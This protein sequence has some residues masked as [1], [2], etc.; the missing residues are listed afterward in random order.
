MGAQRSKTPSS[1]TKF[2]KQDSFSNFGKNSTLWNNLSLLHQFL[3]AYKLTQCLYAY[4]LTQ[5]QCLL[6]NKHV[7]FKLYLWHSWIEIIMLLASPYTYKKLSCFL[8]L[9]ILTKNIN[10]ILTQ[11]IVILFS[12]H[13]HWTEKGMDGRLKLEFELPLL[14]SPVI[15]YPYSYKTRK[16]FNCFIW[17][18]LWEILNALV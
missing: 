8:H 7:V 18:E 4:K 5:F 9:L 10:K 1:I 14:H 13:I 17:L 11:L 16:R 2:S 15:F 12:N 3:Y 6:Q